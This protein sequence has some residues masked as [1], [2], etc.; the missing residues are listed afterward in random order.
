MVQKAYSKSAKIAL[1]SGCLLLGQ[2]VSL[3]V[4][5]ASQYF[6]PSA[7]SY[8]AD[9]TFSIGIYADSAEE[10]AS[11]FSGLVYFPVEKLN[12][13]SLSKA[14]SIIS[15]WVREPAY[16]N[17]EGTIS[18][19]GLIPNPGFTGSGGKLLTVTFKA[20]GE[21]AVDLTFLEGAI[22]ANDGRGSDITASLGAATFAL[23][24][25]AERP[26]T[27]TLVNSNLAV[28]DVSPRPSA[29]VAGIQTA[30]ASAFGRNTARAS[31]SGLAD[32]SLDLKA[33]PSQVFM[34]FLKLAVL[35]IFL[36]L[37]VIALAF[38]VFGILTFMHRHTRKTLVVLQGGGSWR[39]R[40][41]LK[42]MRRDVHRN[43]HRLERVSQYELSDSAKR[44]VQSTSKALVEF[45]DK[46]WRALRDLD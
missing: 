39:L 34:W 23:S 15:L 13:V 44:T 27:E 7:G 16:S 18:F 8:S 20:L 42:R 26:Q 45:E 41:N 40:Q 37:T 4:L 9:S 31:D 43:I 21:D 1:L 2:L 3:P 17:T 12:V 30:I 25:E 28:A 38:T 46:V 35:L 29:Q 19:E 33:G 14:G 6:S 22:L 32:L 5:A 11:A 24:N 10:A 36:T